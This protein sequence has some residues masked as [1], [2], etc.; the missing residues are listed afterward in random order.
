M[1][2]LPDEE[3]ALLFASLGLL[4]GSARI[5]G[6]LAVR[7][8]QPAVVGEI[9]AGVLW[10]PSVLGHLAPGLCEALFPPVGP[11]AIVLDGLTSI[12]IAPYLLVAGMEAELSAVFRQRKAALLV[13]CAGLLVPFGVGFASAW[14]VPAL[15]GA[16]PGADRLVF[17]LILATA[18][19]ISALPVIARTLLDLRLFKT[20][21]GMIVIAAAVAGDL[22]GWNI[23]A[24]VMGLVNRTPGSGLPVAATVAATL[25]FAV[26]MLTV[27][28]CV[29]HRALPWLVAYTSWPGGVL[30]AA[31]VL[32][33]LAAGLTEWI[34]VHAVFG[35]FLTGVALGDS[36]HL[37]EETRTTLLNFVSFIFAP[38]FFASIGLKVDF[39]SAFEPLLVVAIFLIACVGKMAG[40]GGAA[41][42]AGL[43]WRTSLSIGAALNARG[44]MEIIL[45]LL[46]LEN[47]LISQ[48][49][50]VALVVMT[51]GTSM[52]SG[53]IMRGL[54]GRP[55][56]ARIADLLSARTFCPRLQ[57]HDARSAIVELSRFF[58]GAA[59]AW[60][61]RIADEA[62]DRE[63]SSST[64]LDNGLA[65]PFAQ[66]AGLTAPLAAVGI[67]PG[68]ID[69][70]SSD[71]AK[72]HVDFLLAIP[73]NQVQTQVDLLTD[74][75]RTFSRPEVTE[76]AAQAANFT[77]FLATPRTHR[78]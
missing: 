6:E 69:F 47:G 77:E 10:G 13:G 36:H 30:G 58:E 12:S 60:A 9:L 35:A 25:G 43:D 27:G 29:F 34:G 71:G 23:F 22:L 75:A 2:R 44:A 74:A 51:L 45:G 52:M 28:R 33:L 1:Q 3:L 26:A 78:P 7:F 55:A 16:E 46:A 64:G 4:L 32:G 15:M 66:V 73:E 59:G 20:D 57:A 42:L 14:S 48:S 62:W 41:R 67:S 54:L 50:F 37:R 19:S 65:V 31:V 21:L 24:V 70:N 49:V 18:L 53:P 72:S 17:S 11:R 76:A 56:R 61:D 5:L 68:G 39:A 63:Q 8:K 40:C 38:L